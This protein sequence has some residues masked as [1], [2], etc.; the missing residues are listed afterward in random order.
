M[1]SGKQIKQ[2]HIFEALWHSVCEIMLLL[3]SDGRIVAVNDAAVCAY[4][5]KR[6][7]ML[8]MTLPDL[9]DGTGGFSTAGQPFCGASEGIHFRKDGSSFPVE[10][11]FFEVEQGKTAP[12]FVLVRDL[13]E[14]KR[15]ENKLAYLSHVTEQSPCSVVITDLEGKIEYVNPKF[16]QITGYDREE[17]IGQFPSIL[18]SGYQPPE[19]YQEL[20]KVISAGGEWRGEFHNK[21]KNGDLYWELASISAIKSADGRIMKYLA[22]KEDITARK[23]VEGALQLAEGQLREEVLLAGKIQRRFLPPAFTDNKVSINTIYEPYTLVSGDTFDYFWLDGTNK[24][25]GYIADVMGHGLPTALQTSALRVLGRPVFEK[26]I[27]LARRVAE[28]NHISSSCFTEDSFAALIAFEFDFKAGTLTYVAAGINY[29]L[30]YT[31]G[32]SGTV[33]TPGTFI[34]LMPDGDFEQHTVSF[35]AGDT[36]HFLSDGLF[37]LIGKERCMTADYEET[38]ARLREIALSKSRTDDATAIMIQIQSNDRQ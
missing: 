5:Y 15:L 8:A 6:S 29:F 20:W 17:A 33:K 9:G 16:C 19:V 31:S 12:V 2:P 38:V 34:G 10:L 27:P 13:S 32:L 24:L 3:N 37:D 25:V 26:H 18:K 23:E 11:R 4:G 21:K 7:D 14:R 35:S 1:S 36:F 30:A 22:V 28:L